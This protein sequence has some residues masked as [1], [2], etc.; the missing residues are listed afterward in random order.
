MKKL[1]ARQSISYLVTVTFILLAVGVAVFVATGEVLWPL[2][3]GSV[4]GV[5]V[6]LLGHQR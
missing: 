1:P 3:I 5:I 4:A 2:L 6:L